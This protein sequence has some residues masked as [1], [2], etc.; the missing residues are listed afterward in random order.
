MKNSKGKGVIRL[1]DK[2]SH[3]GSVISAAPD[4]K[5]LGKCVAVEG[6]QVT[7]PKCNGVFAITP[8]GGERK[9]RGKEVA[10]DGDKA[11]CG[12]KLLS[13]IG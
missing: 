4:L 6:N 10:Y 13:S 12:A 11:A 9:H 3:G 8:Q 5:A 7:C 2:T 1:G